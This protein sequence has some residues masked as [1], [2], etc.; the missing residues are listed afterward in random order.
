MDPTHDRGDSE[1]DLDLS[2]DSEYESRPEVPKG[3]R[4]PK[5]NVSASVDDQISALAWHSRKLKLSD[6]LSGQQPLEEREKDRSGWATRDQVLD[7]RTRLIL[8]RLI[9][10]EDLAEV[11]GCLA[12][13]K[14]ANVYHALKSVASGAAPQHRAVKVYKTSTMQFK[15]R[16]K[17]VEGDHRFQ[18]GYNNSS[19]RAIARQ[20]A[21]KEMRNLQRIHRA[22]IPSP[23]PIKLRQHV[24][25]MG[26]I[27]DRHGTPAPRL[28]DVRL[29][30]DGVETRWRGLYGQLLRYMRTLHRECQLVHAD[31]S[32][33]NILYHEDRLHLIDVS[34]SVEP[35][36]PEYLAF[37]RSDIKNVTSFFSR[38]GVDVLP[39]KTVFDYVMNESNDVDLEEMLEQGGV[40]L[41]TLE[42]GSAEADVDVEVFRRQHLSRTLHELQEPDSCADQIAKDG[43]D[44]APYQRLLADRNGP[45]SEAHSEHDPDQSSDS[46]EG[47]A[48]AEGSSASSTHRPRG[49]RFED[50]EEKRA[51]KRQVKEEKREKR[52]EKM[53]KSV[54]KSLVKRTAHKKH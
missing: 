29:E 33:Y 30:G 26:F 4:K 38:Q 43:R 12:T 25:V 36:H 21:E 15:A 11:H 27:G 54:K 44:E 19:S 51:H 41:G 28:K 2:T 53:P 52:R 49:K 35:S 37:W 18:S 9:N 17:Y 31:L 50:K 7:D 42:T 24:L 16:S 14:E 23:T 40:P 3:S 5:A 20:W 46:D 13:G 6:E 47:A 39:E 8:L 45:R 32:E 34:Q 48:S 22:S 1:A 10:N